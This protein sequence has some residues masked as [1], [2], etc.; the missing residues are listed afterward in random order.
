MGNSDQITRQYFDSILIEPRYVDAD[1]ASTELKLFGETFKTPIMTAALSH[2][3]NIRPDAMT[4]MAKGAKGAGAVHWYGMGEDTELED[5]TATGAKVVKIIKPHES[6]DEVF[7]R[8]EHAVNAGVFATGMDIDHSF[9]GNGGYDNVIGLPMR[10]KSR[11][12][13]EEYVAASRV[14]FIIKGVLSATDATKCVEAGVSGI[15][16]SHHH[17]IMDYSVPPL[18]VLPEIVTAVNGAIPIFVDCGIVSA[19]DAFKALALGATAV[20]VGRELMGPVKDGHAAVTCRIK[21]MTGQLASIM[22]RTGAKN[23]A[24]IDPSVLWFTAPARH[25]I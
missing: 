11:R 5:L 24:E 14:P 6:E 15:V 3:H 25:N 19:M 4:E 13:L 7:R 12:Q 1:L 9:N 18:M 20:S 17:G 22:A 16:V 21:E 10:S 2:L 23:L 8:I